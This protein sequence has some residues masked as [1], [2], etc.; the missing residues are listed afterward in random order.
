MARIHIGINNLSLV[1]TEENEKNN[2]NPGRL[3]SQT[4]T[5]TN[6]C[7]ADRVTDKYRGE[8]VCSLLSICRLFILGLVCTL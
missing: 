8:Y 4:E 7:M 2:Q 3:A 1:D 5:Q 6:R